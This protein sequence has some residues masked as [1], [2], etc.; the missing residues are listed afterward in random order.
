[1]KKLTTFAVIFLFLFSSIAVGQI[2]GLGR[3]PKVIGDDTFMPSTT[4][5]LELGVSTTDPVTGITT[6]NTFVVS[7]KGGAVIKTFTDIYMANL[8]DGEP[9]FLK[10]VEE[11]VPANAIDYGLSVTFTNYELGLTD[12]GQLTEVYVYNED[13]DKWGRGIVIHGGFVEGPVEGS[14]GDGGVVKGPTDG[15]IEPSDGGV[16]TGPT[17][18]GGRRVERYNQEIVN[19]IKNTE[20]INTLTFKQIEGRLVFS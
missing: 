6:M 1:M 5:M 8:F 16:T 11:E 4:D 19:F 7:E 15:G 9:V 20:P 17:D 13:V 14:P 18:T 3:T 10:T 2:D 12:A